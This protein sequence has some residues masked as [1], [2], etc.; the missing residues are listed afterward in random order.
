[1]L[2]SPPDKSKSQLAVNRPEADEGTV[3]VRALENA[4]YSSATIESVILE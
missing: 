3:H 2:K 1:M 4:E